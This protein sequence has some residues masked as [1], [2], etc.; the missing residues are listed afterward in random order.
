MIGESLEHH[1]G[2]RV[3]LAEHEDRAPAHAVERLADDPALLAQEG[4]H[5]AH[6][7]RDQGR[8][9]ALREPGRVDLLVHVPQA[10]RA[11]DDQHAGALG[12]LEDV[13]AVDVLGVEG[14]ILA[15]QDAVERSERLDGGLAEREP[16]G[17]V[18]PHR[19]RARA[20]EGDAVAQQEVSQLEI[21][22]RKA[23]RLGREQHRESRVFGVVDRADR[24]HHHAESLEWAHLPQ[25]TAVSGPGTDYARRRL[26]SVC[27]EAWRVGAELRPSSKNV[28]RVA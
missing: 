18:R 27:L 3:T 2:I 17:R 10:L 12:A 7:A 19:E 5:L 11:V 25:I 14:R 1:A 23:T 26:G 21:G 24:I 13:G 16:A 4:R 15:H 6:V 22:E 9:A 8:R 28:T 20:P